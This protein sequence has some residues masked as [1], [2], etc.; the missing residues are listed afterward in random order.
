MSKVTLH[1]E[2]QEILIANGNR[3]M[4]THKI[5]EEVN[6]RNRY[7]KKDGSEV[8]DYQIHGRTRV[9]NQLFEK[10][11]NRVRCRQYKI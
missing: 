10:N 7:Q 5:A 8:T 6:R 9:Y 11:G 3:W 2:I 4:T 1:D